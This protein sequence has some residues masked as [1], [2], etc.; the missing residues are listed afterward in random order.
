MGQ[1]IPVIAI[2]GGPCSGKTSCQGNLKAELESR[3][4]T[5]FFVPEAATLI[6]AHGFDSAALADEDRMFDFQSI[7]T[8]M[9]IALE[10]RMKEAAKLAAK[11]GAKNPVVLCDRGIADNEAY[12]GRENFQRILDRLGLTKDEI[13]ARYDMVVHLVT[14]AKGAV[15]FYDYNNPERYE[16]PEQAALVDDL[17]LASWAAHPRLVVLEN[18]ETTPDGVRRIPFSEKMDRLTEAVLDALK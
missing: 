6:F 13:F 10:N 3:G 2:T 17:Q 15:E 14:A 7:I 16:T 11:A 1:R 12:T 4:F 18:E 9:Q 5:P 8:K